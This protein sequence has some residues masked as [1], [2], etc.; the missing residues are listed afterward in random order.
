MSMYWWGTFALVILGLLALDLGL[1]T[2]RGKD[3]TLRQAL[4]GVAFRVAVAMAFNAA[5]YFGWVGA[6][7]TP[8]LQHQAGLEFLTG[9]IVE[10][11]LS[12][13]NVFVFAVIFRYFKVPG[14]H[15]HRVLFWGIV[16]ALVM[17]AA[18]I[19]AGI[20]LMNMFAWVVYIFA[21]ILIYGGIR[22][23]RSD[24]GDVDPAAN[25][26]L[27]L[28]RKTVPITPHFVEDRFITKVDGRWFATPLLVV[29][30]VIE[31]TDLVFAVD[32]IPAVLAVTRD[33][34]IVFTSNV[35]AILGLRALYFALAGVLKFFRFLHYG[36]SAILVFVGVKMLLAHTQFKLQTEQSL[37]IVGSLLGASI[38]AS[39]MF[40]K[41]EAK[42]EDEPPI[43]D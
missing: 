41:K 18:L 3:M 16:G 33:P 5:I 25:P 22:M 15:Q 21:V 1:F 34:F 43:M 14:P 4:G 42:A 28:F 10:I 11:A 37:I 26:L 6:Y 7:A 38:I 2:K 20:A 27:R 13:D 35:F 39:L 8:E 29:L 17:R 30:I 23:I 19:G 36:L 31:T 12:I 40:P 9:Y 24:A 32:S